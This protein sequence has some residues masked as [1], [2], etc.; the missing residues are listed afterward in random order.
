M[1]FAIFF[2]HIS[3]NPM[4][5]A[6]NQ[7]HSEFMV[8]FCACAIEDKNHPQGEEFFKPGVEASKCHYVIQGKLAYS[9]VVPESAET[10]MGKS[11]A[12]SITGGNSSYLMNGERSIV[13]VG[14]QRW[15]TEVALWT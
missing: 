2:P 8:Q 11:H 1:R 7:A 9:F 12:M 6:W 4:F 5:L 14:S 3:C 13:D 10:N 15:N